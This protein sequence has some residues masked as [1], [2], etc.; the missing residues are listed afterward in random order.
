[1]RHM[2][3][4]VT[5]AASLATGCSVAMS[6][7]NTV[8]GSGVIKEETRTVGDFSSV[9][10]GQAIQATITVGPETSVRIEGDDNILPILKTEVRDGKLETS[11][12]NGVSVWTDKP[13]MMTIT[14]P[15]L[16]A[17]GASGASKVTAIVKP[18]DSFKVDSSGA[19]HVDVTGVESDKL[20]L[21]ASGASQVTVAGTTKKLAVEMSGASQIHANSVPA[22]SVSVHGSGASQAEVQ[23][24]G[25]IKGDLSGATSVNVTGKPEKKDVSTSGAS[26]V[27]YK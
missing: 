6:G 14:T 18:T 5:V 23:T 20:E 8:K 3:A 21:G 26:H 25:S 2:I 11:F 27:S 19:S 15:K 16:T 24:N 17:I 7:L 4:L 9:D 12:E 13:I 1:M 10:I 22:E